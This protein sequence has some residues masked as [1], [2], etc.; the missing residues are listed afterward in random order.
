M[1]SLLSAS[2]NH[3]HLQLS[4]SRALTER[5]EPNWRTPDHQRKKMRILAGL[6]GYHCNHT[7]LQ[8]GPKWVQPGPDWVLS[9]S[10]PGFAGSEPG[11]GWSVPVPA[12]SDPLQPGPP[13]LRALPELLLIPSA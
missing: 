10:M 6:L 13:H 12:G 1:M 8:L 11:P 9:G 3:N 7:N 4:A 5:G 2:S